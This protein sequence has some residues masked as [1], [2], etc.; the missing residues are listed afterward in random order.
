MLTA[1]LAALGSAAGFSVSNAMQHQSAGAAPPGKRGP[2]G[3]MW[4][5]AQRPR[6]VLATALGIVSFALHGVAVHAGA[7]A[8]VQP[9]ATSGMV[10]AILGR[11]VL[12]RKR[13]SSRDV[14]W[15][16][17]TAAGLTVFVIAANPRVQPVDHQS[18]TG[19]LFAVSG[20]LVAVALS[21]GARRQDGA[22]ARGMLL[23]C[24]AGVVFGM[25][26]GVFKLTIATAVDDGFIALMATWPLWMMLALGGSGV[27][28]NQHAYQRSP[29]AVTMPVLNV[30][31][32]L[33]A[34]GFGYAVFGEVPAH[35][36]AA[37]VAE[38]SALAL[39]GVGL[40]Q[41]TR[42]LGGSFFRSAPV[43][44]EQSDEPA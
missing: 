2:I 43:A 32:V 6:W 20:A 31:D 27:V 36:P 1:V 35:G 3:L 13:P 29:L 16:F 28:L 40:R 30:V 5:L 7:L 8:V 33:V 19:L 22:N 21:Y 23:G 15:A 26:A 25:L 37:L 42:E 14:G 11:P 38:G 12:D 17:A 18:R 10:L 4:H 9:I 24:S 39:M 44:A 41:L 34:V